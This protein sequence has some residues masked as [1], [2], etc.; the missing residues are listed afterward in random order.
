M[1][2][3]PT[4]VKRVTPVSGLRT[5]GWAPSFGIRYS[6]LGFG[7]WTRV[8]QFVVRN[9]GIESVSNPNRSRPCP[10]QI[11]RA[12]NSLPFSK[13]AAQ[14]ES[15]KLCAAESPQG[16][17][18]GGIH[19]PQ[20]NL[21]PVARVPRSRV[22]QTSAFEVCGSSVG[23]SAN[24]KCRGMRRAA[25]LFTPHTLNLRDKNRGPQKR[26]SA[27]RPLGER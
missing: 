26:R 11:Y 3:F 25:F 19:P 1:A 18:G 20:K 22:A 15:C 16:G 27:L 5:R 24:S 4:S 21:T 6:G 2:G 12:G 7:I 8:S 23:K 10:A 13:N 17:G 9:S 14:P